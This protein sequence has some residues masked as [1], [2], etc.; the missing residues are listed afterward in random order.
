MKRDDRVKKLKSNKLYVITGQSFSKGRSLSS[1]VKAALE[2]GAGIIQLREKRMTGRELVE[3]GLAVRE[4]TRES[5]ALFI[6]N[7][8]LDIALAVG[9]DGV[10]LGQDD[11]PLEVARRVAGPDMIIGISTH[12]LDQAI[13]AERGGADYIGVGPLFETRSK[14]DICAP[15]GLD[16]LR[17][18]SAGVRIPKVGIG[19]V[20]DHNVGSVMEAGADMVAVIT[21]VVAAPDVAGAARNLINRINSAINDGQLT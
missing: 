13:E 2:G 21:A 16:L 19:G 12:S 17:E 18:V 8:R 4:L 3:A 9:A 5:G 14:E 11:M 1:V 6:V 10:H 7:D 20:K 15:V